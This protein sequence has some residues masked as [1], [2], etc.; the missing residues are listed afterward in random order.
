MIKMF[1]Q[2]QLDDN[3]REALIQQNV[4]DALVGML[5]S[6]NFSLEHAALEAL[7]KF[8]LHSNSK[9]CFAEAGGFPLV[10]LFLEKPNLNMKFKFPS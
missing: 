3:R 7:H 9:K 5:K 10:L 4:I 8:S 1:A 6:R 2:L